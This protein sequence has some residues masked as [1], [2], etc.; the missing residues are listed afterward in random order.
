MEKMITGILAKDTYS[1]WGEIVNIVA[2]KKGI[3]KEFK[4]VYY[5]IEHFYKI[6]VIVFELV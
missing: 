5:R 1:I 3:Y 2:Y 6:C 4:K